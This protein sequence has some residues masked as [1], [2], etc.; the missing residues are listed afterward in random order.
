MLPQV[1]GGVEV[2]DLEMRWLCRSG[3]VREVLLSATPEFD[4][5]GTAKRSLAVLRD[6]TEENRVRRALEASTDQL[7][8]SLEAMEEYAYITS[9]DLR[10]PL[11]GISALLEFM[12]EDVSPELIAEIR[13]WMEQLR[14]RVGRMDEMLAG[15]L[16]YARAGADEPGLVPDIAE[17]AELVSTEAAEGLADPSEHELSISA[18]AETITD[19]CLAK[20]T[21][22]HVLSN[23]ITNAFVHH[24][25]PR[26]RVDVTLKIEADRL[27]LS[28][29]DDGPGIEPR[30]HERAFQI[31][32][33]AG[34]G[35]KGSSGMGLALVRRMM[36]RAGGRVTLE[37]PLR[38]GRGCRFNA[39]FPWR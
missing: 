21:F 12:H 25:R 8:V 24:D 6:V 11:R 1:V 17:Y 10:T 31:F 23:L 13:P 37:S 4:E 26:Q 5:K 15:L 18:P 39:F 32:R 30:Q 14:E 22:R 34:V 7:R 29:E 38:D 35:K 28:V 33:T 16:R 36:N 27:V 9:H 3:E 20:L 2:S 19:I